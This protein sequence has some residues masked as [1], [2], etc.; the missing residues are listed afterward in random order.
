MKEK[1]VT[2]EASVSGGQITLDKVMETPPEYKGNHDLVVEARERR[3]YVRVT[4]TGG[5][6]LPE[7]VKGEAVQVAKSQ[8]E[9][10]EPM[11]D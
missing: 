2:F 8:I 1:H 6:S 9:Q 3:Y 10:S 11:R 7:R 4:G 5:W